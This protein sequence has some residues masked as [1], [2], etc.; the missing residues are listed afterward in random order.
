M[1]KVTPRTAPHTA[2]FS[3]IEL[4]IVILIASLFAALVFNNVSFSTRKQTSVGI[5][6]LKEKL[7]GQAGDFELVC[8]D[9]C[10]QCRIVS[11][12]KSSPIESHLPDMTAYVLDDSNNPQAIDFGRY[13]D[14]KICLRFHY[15]PN[16]STSQMILAPKEEDRFYFIPSYFGEIAVFDDLDS[17]VAQWRKYRDQLDSMGGFY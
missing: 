7:N 11:G 2:A 9:H 6:Q 14:R 4:I 10:K 15:Y 5:R 3:L 16:G 17:A 13:H 8:T 12:A 1:R